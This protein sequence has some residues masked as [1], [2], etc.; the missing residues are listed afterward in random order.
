M[1]NHKKQ[2]IFI[3]KGKIL[4]KID[5]NNDIYLTHA[6]LSYQA[7][8]GLMNVKKM[9]NIKFRRSRDV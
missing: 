5:I 6:M 8:F 3:I 2:A 4:N 7:K 9:C 1:E